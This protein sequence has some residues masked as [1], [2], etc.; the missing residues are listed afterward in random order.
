MAHIISNSGHD[1]RGSYKWGKA[2]D[3]TGDEWALRSWYNRPWTHVL[4]YPDENVGRLI[5]ELAVEGAQ[6]NHIGY[7]QEERYT[8]WDCLK[9]NGF[10]P[11][12]IKTNCEAD[13]T[14][15]VSACIKATGYLLGIENLKNISAYLYSGN[16]RQ[17]LKA[18]GFKVLTA[19]KYLSSPSYLMAGDILLC[20]EHHA[21]T[22]ISYGD[23]VSG[24]GATVTDLTPYKNRVGS[25][26]HSEVNYTEETRNWLQKGDKGDKV[27]E[28]QNMLIAVGYN[29]GKSGADG[30]F[31]NDTLAA[32]IKF[33]TDNKLV[34]DGEYG[35]NSEKKLKELYSKKV[36]ATI[37]KKPTAKDTVKR[38]QGVINRAYTRTIREVLNGRLLEEN[39][40]F[41]ADD[42]RVCLAIFKYIANYQYDARLTISN[43]NF[44][45]NCKA[46]ATK[47][48]VARGMVNDITYLVEYMLAGV[49]YYNGA[50]NASC[51]DGLVKAITNWQKDNGLTQTGAFGSDSWYKYFN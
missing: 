27:K 20:E 40:V 50:M 7:D 36:D 51:G 45:S 18:A 32:V 21:A 43:P 8:L 22:N 19:N 4:R 42:K 38:A 17:A 44:G 41:G 28:M 5:A 15:G 33:Q 3:Q 9:V 10:R 11:A 12:N 2:G 37:S 13:C 24:T 29:C 31:G 16:M 1:E 14:A 46:V 49:G 25:E 35:V 48:V 26:P 30:D 23:K 39:G 47:M 34:V 6:N